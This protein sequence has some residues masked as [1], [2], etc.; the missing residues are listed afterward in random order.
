M[1]GA[2]RGAPVATYPSDG[3][4]VLRFVARALAEGM[5]GGLLLAL[6]GGAALALTEGGNPLATLVLLPASAPTGLLLGLLL[7]ATALLVLTVELALVRRAQRRLRPVALAT[8][9]ALVVA[10]LA[11]AT[12][13][14]LFAGLDGGGSYRSAT[15]LA[16][17]A[18]LGGGALALWRITE[19][20]PGRG[21]A[22][23]RDADR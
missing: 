5:V 2:G 22:A 17:V 13:F 3:T 20:L 14:L 23:V 10:I 6:L 9:P 16:I 8:G 18:S 19:L 21:F 12:V 15:V 1:A 7:V 11:G 4:D